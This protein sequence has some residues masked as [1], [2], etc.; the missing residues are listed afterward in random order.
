MIAKAGAL[1][2]IRADRKTIVQRQA[3]QGFLD[4]D[5]RMDGNA[6]DVLFSAS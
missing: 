4:D 3:V 2:E 5:V 1:A 6:R